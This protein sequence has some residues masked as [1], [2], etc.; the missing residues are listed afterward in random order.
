MAAALVVVVAEVVEIF[1]VDGLT[2]DSV[3]L[4][5]VTSDGSVVDFTVVELDVDR[6]VVVGVVAFVVGSVVGASVVRRVVVLGTG[7]RGS[8]ESTTP[9]G[10]FM[11]I[12]DSGQV[13][14]SGRIE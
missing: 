5:R 14:S 4:S 6:E 2:V 11:S 7:L 1:V 13:I 12:S 9:T 8:S 3:V 10:P